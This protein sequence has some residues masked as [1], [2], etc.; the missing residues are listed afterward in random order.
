MCAGNGKVREKPAEREIGTWDRDN[1]RA[2]AR[3]PGRGTPYPHARMPAPH[4]LRA[5][6]DKLSVRPGTALPP[7]SR[8][9][10]RPPAPARAPARS[11][12]RLAAPPRAAEEARRS[13]APPAAAIAGVRVT[14]GCDA[15]RTAAAARGSPSA[16]GQ[17]RG[18]PTPA[19]HCEGPA[20]LRAEDFRSARALTVPR[21]LPVTYKSF[22]APSAAPPPAG[23]H[24]SRKDFL[25]G[26]AK[27]F[28]FLRTD[29]V[30]S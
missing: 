24:A 14:T 18:R 25:G 15:G 5:C 17:R 22:S 16:G 28:G 7:R 10:G 4:L 21:V 2:G 3:S 26:G 30:L 20:G 11:S 6:A 29:A 19:G 12:H 23:P 27:R 1:P 9:P 13:R 8:L